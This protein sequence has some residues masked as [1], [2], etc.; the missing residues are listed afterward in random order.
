MHA[1]V[2][3]RVPARWLRNPIERVDLGEDSLQR[4][5]TAQSLEEDVGPRLTERALRFLPDPLRNQCV[6]L[7]GRDHTLHE[8]TRIVGYAEA[9]IGVTSGKA[10]DAEDPHGVFDERFRHV[11][12]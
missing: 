4:T 2:D 10:R 9:Q 1:R 11:A 12:Q 8:H 5:T 7:A 6:N 3:F